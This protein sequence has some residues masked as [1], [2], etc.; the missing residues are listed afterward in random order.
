MTENAG[1]LSSP[2]ASRDCALSGFSSRTLGPSLPRGAGRPELSASVHLGM[3]VLQEHRS[4]P[5]NAE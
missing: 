4:A 3:A 1:M 5:A 2:R